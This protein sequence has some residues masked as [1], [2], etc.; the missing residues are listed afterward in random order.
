MPAATVIT[1]P[2]I[3]TPRT[4]LR[5]HRRSDF[6]TYAEMWAQPEV[7][8]FIGG[9]PRARD[10]SWLRF[11]RHAG[12]WSMM[13]YGFWGVEEKAS[14]RFI[15]EAGFLELKREM[16]PSIE[17]IPEVGWV[18]APAAHG[19]GLATEVVQAAL[20][21]GEQAMPGVRTVCIIDPENHPSIRVAT[22]CGFHNPVDAQ[23]KAERV[24][25]F[26]R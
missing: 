7:T 18:L 21:W 22:K 1:I 23:F 10:D 17:G 2:S 11:L 24:L 20:A 19:R 5:A 25:L 26:E 14:G 8:R 3:E 13:G 9:Q 12:I 16:T 4:I 6:D 15:G